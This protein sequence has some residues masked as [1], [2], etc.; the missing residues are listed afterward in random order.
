MRRFQ[1]AI[2]AR[3]TFQA[4]GGLYAFRVEELATGL[5]VSEGRRIERDQRRGEQSKTRKGD[6]PGK[7][8]AIESRDRARTGSQRQIL[9]IELRHRRVGRIGRRVRHRSL[10]RFPAEAWRKR[11]R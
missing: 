5:D 10:S 2:V 6:K 7:H 9:R 11:P 8:T 1:L 4:F 3:Q